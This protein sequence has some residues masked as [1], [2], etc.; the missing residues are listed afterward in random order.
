EHF[1]VAY[2]NTRHQLI[3]HKILF[4]GTVNGASVYPREVVKEALKLN[5]TA[6]IVAHNHPSG[7]PTPS[8]DDKAITRRLRDA[9]EL[10]DIRLLDHIIVGHGKSLSM[11]DKGLIYS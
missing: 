6:I 4:S 7:N 5:A 9:L 11:A 8:M 2:F 1:W 10:V 3:E